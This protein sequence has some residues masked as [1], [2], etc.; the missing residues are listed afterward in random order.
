MQKGA[1]LPENISKWL[2]IALQNIAC[3]LDA[4]AVLNVK[5]EKQGVRKDS[6]LREIQKKFSNSFI[7]SGTEATTDGTPP[8]KT[9]RA[10]KE[11]S[12]AMPAKKKTTARKNWNRATTDR[13]PEFTLGK[14]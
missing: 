12:Q 3:G 6:F 11:I 1:P 8:K 13:K 7:A 10:I 2:Y 5:P 4:N 14:K 9:T